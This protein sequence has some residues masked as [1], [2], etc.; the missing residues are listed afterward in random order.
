MPQ[1]RR[2][3]TMR[4]R[5]R[6]ADIGDRTSRAPRLILAR[7]AAAEV[8]SAKL[9]TRPTYCLLLLMFATATACSSSGSGDAQGA[10]TA[11]PDRS[12]G[13]TT[14]AA[15]TTAATTAAAPTAT[16]A[17]T[18]T[19]AAASG[20]PSATAA[21]TAGPDGLSA[22]PTQT[23]WD[24]AKEVTVTGSTALGC[25]TTAVR[26]YLKVACKGQNSS[27]GTPTWLTVTKGAGRPGMFTFNQ[28]AVTSLIVPFIEGVDV[29]ADF[30]WTNRTHTL[31]V[32]WP[33]GAPKPAAHGAFDAGRPNTQ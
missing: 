24:A 27:G 16:V 14:A 12:A 25:K 1:G 18:A 20:A 31:T 7:G 13:A 19:A 26:E 5:A 22:A 4:A 8:P 9:M 3:D 2:E 32:S 28:N 29:T 33:R 21:G 17:T 6:L 30:S 10:P 11:K 15:P 23:E